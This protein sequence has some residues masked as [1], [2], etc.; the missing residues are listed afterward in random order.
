MVE[1]L[2]RGEIDVIQPPLGSVGKLQ[3]ETGINILKWSSRSIHELGFNTWSDPSSKG[4]PALKDYRFRQ[5]L[6][7]AVNKTEIVKLAFHGLALPA[8]SVLPPKMVLYHWDPSPEEKLEFNLAKANAMLDELG[9]TKWDASHTY[10]IDPTTN[11]AFNLILWVT[12]DAVE[13]ISAGSL[14][15]TWFKEIGIGVQVRVA[16]SAQMLDANLAGA[17]DMYLWGWGFDADPDF[18][19]SVFTT[20]QIGVWSDCFYSNET[21]DAALPEAAHGHRHD[22]TKEHNH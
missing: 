3:N 16:D 2:I 19:L 20:G 1:A 11:S 21:Y 22:R 13:L 18:A 10:R 5:A 6:A 4:N 8:E 7:H 15:E 14:I 12:N 9:Y 17:M